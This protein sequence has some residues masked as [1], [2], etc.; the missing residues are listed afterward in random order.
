VRKLVLPDAENAPTDSSECS[1]HRPVTLLVS[2]NLANPVWAVACRDSTVVAAA[3]PKA[4]IDKN[5]K[6]HAGKDK[7]RLA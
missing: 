7:V 5:C 3:V 2:S 1:G 4:A 6:L